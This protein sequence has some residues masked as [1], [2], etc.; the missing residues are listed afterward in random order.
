[1][2]RESEGTKVFETY[3]LAVSPTNNDE[4]NMNIQKGSGEK[5]TSE[6]LSSANPPTPVA[7]PKPLSSNMDSRSVLPTKIPSFAYSNV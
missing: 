4:V 7:V 6:P 3:N 2:F 1:M 5:D